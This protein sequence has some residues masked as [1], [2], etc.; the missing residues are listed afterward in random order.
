M[1]A[2]ELEVH[3]QQTSGQVI[4]SSSGRIIK[5]KHPMTFP[6]LPTK[7]INILKKANVP[8]ECDRCGFILDT[9]LRLISHLNSHARGKKHQCRNCDRTFCNIVSL[10]KHCAMAHRDQNPFKEKRFQCDQCP[11]RYLTEFLL[12]Q[13]KLSH[14]NLK[15]EKCEFCSFATNAPYDLKNHIKRIHQASKDYVCPEKDCGKAFKRRCDMENHRKSVHST[16]K[17]YVKC[18]TCDVIVLEKGLQSHMINRHSEKALERPHVCQ[19]CGKSERYEK[20]LKRHYEAVHEPSDRGVTYQCPECPQ[21]FYRRREL[22]AHSFEHF[23][24]RVH[25]CDECGNK[26]K[27]KKE[28]TNHV[29]LILSLKN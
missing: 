5:R 6:Q 19:I 29:S 9:K 18:P 23:S 25:Q 3:R 2:Y 14:Q 7:P 21:M 20:N 13:H 1:G 28:L 17:V 12:G 4:T 22:T 24:G 16:V 10:K 15:N 26:Y 8:F 11:K 27:S